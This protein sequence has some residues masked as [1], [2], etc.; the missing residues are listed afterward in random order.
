MI[1]HNTHPF[2]KKV[3]LVAEPALYAAHTHFKDYQISYIHVPVFQKTGYD[4]NDNPIFTE[5]PLFATDL[6]GS[7]VYAVNPA[8]VDR[9]F[10][11][12][13]YSYD[14][15]A[16]SITFHLF[17]DSF[18]V[19]SPVADPEQPPVKFYTTPPVLFT[20]IGDYEDMALNHLWF[21]EGYYIK[22]I[23]QLS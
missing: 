1:N 11:G 6:F 4:Q 9:I 8:I 10:Y 16:E 19:V 18:K 3:S 17:N 14:Q 15:S 5:N 13:V 20:N 12:Q 7:N 2:D 22:R 21:F 23:G